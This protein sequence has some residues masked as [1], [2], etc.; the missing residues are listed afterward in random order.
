L[1]RQLLTQRKDPID[2]SQQPRINSMR[3]RN[4]VHVRSLKTERQSACTLVSDVLAKCLS[5]IKAA[6]VWNASLESLVKRNVR[7]FGLIFRSTRPTT[8]DKPSS[9]WFFPDVDLIGIESCFSHKPPVLNYF[10]AEEVDEPFLW[11]QVSRFI[12]EID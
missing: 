4:G 6:G 5:E 9:I 7:G 11:E 10:D 8:S 3:D 1:A 12:S 2:S